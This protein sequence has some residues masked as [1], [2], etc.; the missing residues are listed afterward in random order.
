MT[1]QSLPR[2]IAVVG[3]GIAALGAVHCFS[4][5]PTLHVDIFEA[6]TYAGGH[7]HTVYVEN[8]DVCNTATG[9]SNGHHAKSKSNHAQATS[10]Q[11]RTLVSDERISPTQSPVDTG[12]I[13]MNPLT[14]PNMLSLLAQLGI[15]PTNSDMS[16]SVSRRDP[17]SPSK[18]TLE[19]A[20]KSL[21]TLF[22]DWQNLWV[23]M[24]GIWR[25]AYDAWKFGEEAEQYVRK[26]EEEKFD[27]DGKFIG[28]KVESEGG[29]GNT[30]KGW[31]GGGWDVVLD[32]RWEEGY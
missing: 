11:Q 32:L 20:G 31:F 14:Y 28:N 3:S 13:V 12:F 16:F 25:L 6:G 19:W 10:T 1:D 8:L 18:P 7:T 9:G 26:G 2:R 5:D 23:G 15:S 24:G 22:A 27:E 21:G 4:A 30:K 29:N 17:Q